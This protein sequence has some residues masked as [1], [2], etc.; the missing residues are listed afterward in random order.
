VVGVGRGGGV[1][2]AAVVEALV[3][4]APVVAAGDGA[5]G[6]AGEAV[7]VLPVASGA[8]AAV[9]GVAELREAGVDVFRTAGAGVTRP[10]GAVSRVV[11]PA[12]A[13]ARVAASSR[14]ASAAGVALLVFT[15]SSDALA[16]GLGVVLSVREARAELAA[17]AESTFGPAGCA[18]LSAPAGARIAESV[19]PAT[20]AL[21]VIAALSVVAA[22]AVPSSAF[23]P[24]E[25]ARVARAKTAAAARRARAPSV[26]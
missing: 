8:D 11:A 1:S 9:L 14:L 18:M 22:I 21:A 3:L 16:T 26:T 5:V 7:P 12:R 6:E 15:C 25:H 17:R 13:T 19:A 24:P 23:S 4:L 10:A 20:G 2:V